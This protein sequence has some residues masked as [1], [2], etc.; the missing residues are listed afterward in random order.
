L[1]EEVK[2]QSK[3]GSKE[4]GRCEGGG[5]WIKMRGEAYKKAKQKRVG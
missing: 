1:T 3:G 5:E 2:W 4:Q